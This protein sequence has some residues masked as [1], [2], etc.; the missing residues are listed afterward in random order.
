MDS[1]PAS[2]VVIAHDN[3]LIGDGLVLF[4]QEQLGVGCRAVPVRDL[5]L[6]TEVVTPA[7]RAIVLECADE[8]AAGAVRACEPH[9]PVVDITGAV[10]LAPGRSAIGSCELLLDRLRG[11]LAAPVAS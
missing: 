7:T 2:V 10:S 3:R 1:S 11:F 5:P 8:D 4:L 9:V 6:L